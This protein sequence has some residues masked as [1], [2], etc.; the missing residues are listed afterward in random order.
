MNYTSG[1]CQLQQQVLEDFDL[2]NQRYNLENRDLCYPSI[3]D[4]AA[5]HCPFC[6]Q[7]YPDDTDFDHLF[8]YDSDHP[9]NSIKFCSNSNCQLLA[10]LSQVRYLT[11]QLKLPYSNLLINNAT[12]YES[13][14]HGKSYIVEIRWSK[15]MN[16]PV[17]RFQST[18]DTSLFYRSFKQVEE[19]NPKT[20]NQ[21]ISK[22][23]WPDFYPKSL[24]AAFVNEGLKYQ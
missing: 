18:V 12:L 7:Y 4:L 6:Q 10:K 14:K 22:I 15:T 24:Q 16:V 5:R 19:L 13:D 21:L 9:Q 3:S 8:V 23:E 2:I 20:I 1:F 11:E 17:I